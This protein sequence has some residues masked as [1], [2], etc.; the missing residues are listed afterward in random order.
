MVRVIDIFLVAMFCY[1]II[2]VFIKAFICRPLEH[3]WNPDVDGT[4]FNQRSLILADA[5]IS[6]I[7][8]AAI[9]LM[10]FLMTRPLRLPWRKR[11]R[12]AAILG[13]GGIACICTV[14]R[15]ADIVENGES[16]DTT[17][18]FVRISLWGYSQQ[19]CLGL[20]GVIY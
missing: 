19:D 20:F 18:V 1:Y 4:C 8:D 15:L 16:N 10:P 3:F 6:V 13:A 9:L 11:L 12:V 14:I 2:L 17:Y 5:A 7:S